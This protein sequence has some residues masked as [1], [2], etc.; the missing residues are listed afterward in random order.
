LLFILG[1]VLTEPAVSNTDLAMKPLRLEPFTFVTGLVIIFGD[2][3]IS[4]YLRSAFIPQNPNLDWGGVTAISGGLV[5]LLSLV[6][7][8]FLSGRLS[9]AGV[10]PGTA[11]GDS[12]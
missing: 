11:P 9:S 6:L 3:P 5:I 10:E 8:T 2:V 12:P 7:G 4:N 1:K